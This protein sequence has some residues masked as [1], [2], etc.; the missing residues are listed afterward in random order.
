MDF[1]AVFSFFSENVP[2]TAEQR[3]AELLCVAGLAF[4]L[5]A[6]VAGLLYKKIT[7]IKHAKTE[8]KSE[9]E[10]MHDSRKEQRN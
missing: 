2:L 3:S 10:Q 7:R 9:T 4:L 1:F 5:A 6:A 8:N